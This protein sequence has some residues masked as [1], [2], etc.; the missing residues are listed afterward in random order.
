MTTTK[1]STANVFADALSSALIRA[2]NSLKDLKKEIS[3]LNNKHQ[4]P[5]FDQC[6]RSLREV[7]ALRRCYYGELQFVN[8]SHL[9]AEMKSKLKDFDARINS[10]QTEVRLHNAA[11]LQKQRL[12][13]NQHSTIQPEEEQI[14]NIN[15]SLL[16]KTNQIQNKTSTHLNTT[17]KTAIE[18]REMAQDVSDELEMQH[19]T[20][21]NIDSIMS[22]VDGKIVVSKNTVVS[23]S[24]RAATDKVLILFA[25]LFV[26]VIIGLIVVKVLPE[27]ST[28]KI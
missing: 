23:I 17:L 3:T 14:P 19:E 9:K 8:D 22:E 7:I 25:C 20:L 1:P 16:E 24:R 12:L 27:Y 26:G 28:R 5:N 21:K 6:D 2:E 10:F 4:V 11:I 18:M 15:N 13:L